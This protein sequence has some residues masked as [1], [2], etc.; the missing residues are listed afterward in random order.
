[1]PRDRRSSIVTRS[2][3]IAP[4]LALLLEQ[5]FGISAELWMKMRPAS[6]LPPAKDENGP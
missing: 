5:R 2:S 1:V 3:A 4:E 6:V